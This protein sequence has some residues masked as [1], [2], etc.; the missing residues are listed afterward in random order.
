MAVVITPGPNTKTAGDIINLALKMANV[1]GVGQNPSAEDTNDAFT[2]LNM[3]MAQWQRRRYMVYHL[4]DTA[5]TGDGSTSYAIG[6]GQVIN[7]ARPAKIESA[8]ARQTPGGTSYPVD[9]PLNILKSREDYNRISLKTLNAFPQYVF[10]DSGFPVGQI[11]VWPLINNTYELH[12]TVMEQL[13]TFNTPADPVNLPPE[14]LAAL[15]YNLALRLYPMYGLQVDPE[16]KAQAIAAMNIIEA[17]NAQ[18]PRLVMPVMLSSQNRSMWNI[19]GD[20]PA[21]GNV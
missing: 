4:V 5:I 9:Y 11:Y 20:M 12:L 10:Y 13:Q 16:V 1:L 21:G 6:P 15:M 14:Y 2:M 3:M 18:I 7:I 8:F 19:Y 17:A